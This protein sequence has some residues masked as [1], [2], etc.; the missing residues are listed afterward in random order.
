MTECNHEA[1]A[2]SNFRKRK[3]R[4]IFFGGPISS[5]DGALLLRDVDR[6]LGPCARVARRL[7]GLRQGGKPRHEVVAKVRQ[8]M[9]AGALGHADLNDHDVLRRDWTP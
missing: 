3:V 1:F 4:W 9:L 8:R 6:R 7:G 2:V 5:N